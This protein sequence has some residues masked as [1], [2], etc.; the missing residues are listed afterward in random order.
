MPTCTPTYSTPNESDDGVPLAVSG[1]FLGVADF[2]SDFASTPST[3][4]LLELTKLAMQLL[5]PLLAEVRTG[6]VGNTAVQ[7]GFGRIAKAAAEA[8]SLGIG[9]C[10]I[11]LKEHGDLPKVAMLQNQPFAAQRSAAGLVTGVVPKSELGQKA[12]RAPLSDPLEELVPKMQPL[13]G[14]P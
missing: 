11:L 1:N 2:A 14:D 5:L 4:G 6:V 9:L 10:S 12:I 8:L 3:R 13:V 7:N